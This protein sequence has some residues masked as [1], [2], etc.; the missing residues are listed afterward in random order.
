MFIK[1]SRKKIRFA[2][3][4]GLCTVEDLWDLPLSAL[5]NMAIQLN[6][7]IKAQAEESFI[8]KPKSQL[9]TT[10]FEI[11]KFVIDTRV[12][13]IDAKTV[14]AAKAAKKAKL[15]AILERKQDESLEQLSV[16]EIERLLAE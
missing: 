5:D 1:A 6:R 3:S 2:T 7:K 16:E 14:A 15:R 4:K 11:V 13:E 12:A 9:D 10:D 8:S